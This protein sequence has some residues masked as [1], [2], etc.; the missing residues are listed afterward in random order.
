MV[1]TSLTACVG[2]CGKLMEKHFKCPQVRKVSCKR[3]LFNITSINATLTS[4]TG[5]VK[6]CVVLLCS[7]GMVENGLAHHLVFPVSSLPLCF[8]MWSYF[9]VFHNGF[10]RECACMPA[11]CVCVCVCMSVCL[12]VCV[13][14]LSPNF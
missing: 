12:S 5:N 7:Y 14:F 11:L 10:N 13:G 9:V 4:I 2:E 3:S 6:T 1:Y 8:N